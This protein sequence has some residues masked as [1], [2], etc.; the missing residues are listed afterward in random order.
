MS[1]S[2]LNIV[3][4]AELGFFVDENGSLFSPFKNKVIPCC[5]PHGYYRFAVNK[6]ER[7][8]VHRLQAY[9]KYG[10]KIFE[11]GIQV[12]HLNGN[13]LDNSVNNIDIGTASDNCQDKLPCVRRAAA[14][15]AASTLKKLS[16]E[17]LASFRKDRESGYTYRQL[18]KKYNLAKSTV[19]YIV[20]NKTYQE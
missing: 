8:L 15:T 7:V 20:N 5:A 14:K 2:N 3:K 6:H 18:M 17:D 13:S 4:A 16:D 19:S 1:K 11:P 9:Q 12:R 10:D